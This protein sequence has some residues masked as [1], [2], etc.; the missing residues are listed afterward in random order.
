MSRRTTLALL[1]LAFLP[2]LAAAQ[3]PK[4]GGLVMRTRWSDGPVM[5]PLTNSSY[6]APRDSELDG[7]SVDGDRFGDRRFITHSV[8]LLA[9][10]PGSP[11]RGLGFASGAG[12]LRPGRW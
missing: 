9:G 1:F 7:V 8:V 2:L 6:V 3:P 10:T 12:A 5:D 11:T 4:P